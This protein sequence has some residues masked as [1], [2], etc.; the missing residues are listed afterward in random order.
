MILIT[1]GLGF[2]GAHTAKQ[3]LD[4]G[5]E[6]V[7]TRYRVSREPEILRKY[8]GN[9]AKV[10]DLDLANP[11]ETFDIFRQ[12][13][14]TRVVHLAT[15]AWGVT[16]AREFHTNMVGLM[17]LLEAARSAGVSRFVTTSSLAIYASGSQATGPFFENSY[18][19]VEVPLHGPTAYKQMEEILA[20]H[21]ADQTGLDV[22]VARIAII[23]GPLY[24]TLLNLPSQ[25]VYSIVNGRPI[26]KAASSHYCDFC[27]VDDA[28]EGLYQLSGAPQLTSRIFNIGAGKG[29]NSEE[30]LAAAEKLGL[31]STE[32][33]QVKSVI[34]WN[35]NDY[36]DTSLA[37]NEFGYTPKF[38]ILA[39]M[40]DYAQWAKNESLSGK[41]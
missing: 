12:Y 27:Y 10:V 7:L 1:G 25:I 2:I 4:A 36:M 41:S 19:S 3:F 26:S 29:V 23:Y 34:N 21:Y 39:G 30:V 5:H 16:P 38:D 22:R 32:L 17:N 40:A 33:A 14:I 35:E 9:Q 28:A 13:K 11:L 15:T 18:H 6:V 8:L 37:H 31:N 24:R 20:L